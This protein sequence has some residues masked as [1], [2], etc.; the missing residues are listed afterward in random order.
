MVPSYLFAFYSFVTAVPGLF[1]RKRMSPIRMGLIPSLGLLLMCWALPYLIPVPSL[2]VPSGNNPVGTVMYHWIDTSRPEQT[3]EKTNKY[4]EMN[5]QIWYPAQVKGRIQQAP[6]IPELT[7]LSHYINQRLHIPS[8]LLS[9]MRLARTYTYMDADMANNQSLYPVV[10]FSH[11]WPGARYA[12]HYL[13]TDLASKGYVVAVVEHTYGTL[14]TVYPDGRIM[15]QKAPSEFQLPAWD[16][17][18][19]NVWAEDDSFVLDQLEKLNEGIMDKRFN[20]RL[21]LE[22]TAIAGHSFGGDD[23]LAVLRKDKRFKVGISLDGSFYGST[24]TPLSANQSFLWMCTDNYLNGLGLP[25]PSD[26]QLSEEGIQ[27]AVY[28]DWIDNFY[29]RKDQA[30]SEGGQI[31]QLKGI[32]HSSF[33]DFYMY[34]PFLKWKAKAPNPKQS[35]RLILKYVELYLEQ[36]LK[37]H[38]SGGRFEN[39]SH[40]DNRVLLNPSVNHRS[41]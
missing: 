11:G 37:G 21:N 19:D 8:F 29:R 7:G 40:Q 9:Y 18:I 28:N 10:I 16:R 6:Y 17:I 22:E 20:H 2:E 4:R 5:V 33:S 26:K 34:S 25:E 13:V 24:Q 3:M 39:L 31:L 1:K 23:A 15:S 36:Y 30:I 27:R 32:K 14:A 41:S 12:Y 35:H 38:P